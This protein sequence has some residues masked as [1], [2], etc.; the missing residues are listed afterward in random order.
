M[1]TETAKSTC[2]M[3]N[4]RFPSSLTYS[5]GLQDR[6][7]LGEGDRTAL[8][9]GLGVLVGA[10]DGDI[11]TPKAASKESLE[12]RAR[13]LLFLLDLRDALSVDHSCQDLDEG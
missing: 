12:Y 8:E 9:T 3:T 13:F 6:S 4:G 2:R 10:R 11:V 5:T 7:L 1:K